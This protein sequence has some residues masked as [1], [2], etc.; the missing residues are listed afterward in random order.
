MRLLSVGFVV[1]FASATLVAQDP[2]AQ[3]KHRGAAAMG[4]DQDKTTH[5]F[6]LYD[7][8]GAID[9]SVNDAGRREESRRDSIASA[10][11][12]DD[13]RRRR[14]RRADAGPRFEG[15]AGNH[16]TRCEEGG[17]DVH[18]QRDAEG[19]PRRH[20]HEGRR[21]AGGAASVPR[22]P[23]RRTQ[24]RRSRRPRES[25]DDRRVDRTSG[26]GA[27]DRR[28]HRH[29]STL[30]AARPAAGYRPHRR[31]VPEVLG[32]DRRRACTSSSA[33]WTSGFRSRT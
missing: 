15:G 8:G 16:D 22:L 9:I 6:L 5:H 11:H 3:M 31:R 23:D 21:R 30:R 4:F 28:Q 25:D 12:R 17:A 2:H 20:R 33:L 1:M 13:V 7:D 24:D 32:G 26:G 19:R 10:A 18:L 29:P 27:R 14:F